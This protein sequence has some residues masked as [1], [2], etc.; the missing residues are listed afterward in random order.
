MK[1]VIL[2]HRWDG[3]PSADWYPWLKEE[4]EKKNIH[5]F[6]PEMPEPSKPKIEKWVSFLKKEIKDV[7]EETFF[8]GHSIGCQ[9]IMRYIETLEEKTKIGG[10]LFVAGFFLA[11]KLETEEEREIA[12]PWLERPIDTTKVKKKVKQ[13]KAIFSDNDPFVPVSNA[14]QFQEKLG[15]KT[16]IEK[17]QGHFNDDTA[18]IVLKILLEMM[19]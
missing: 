1:K 17:K 3:N 19:Q 18:P 8:V 5:V 16:L 13:I 7:D 6:I 14:K 9:T 11:T 4:V 10:V 2:V 12:K 15:A